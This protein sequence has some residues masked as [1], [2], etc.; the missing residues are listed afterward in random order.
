MLGK[1]ALLTWFIHSSVVNVDVDIDV[2]LIDEIFLF[3]E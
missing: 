3:E 2:N 1:M